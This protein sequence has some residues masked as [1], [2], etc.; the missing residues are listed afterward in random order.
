MFVYHKYAS[1]QRQIIKSLSTMKSLHFWE[2]LYM[3]YNFPRVIKWVKT[4]GAASAMVKN[5]EISINI[6]LCSNTAVLGCTWHV[7]LAFSSL[8]VK[9]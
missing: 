3:G 9:M 4:R 5:I 8:I 6:V 1:K 7:M 2:Y